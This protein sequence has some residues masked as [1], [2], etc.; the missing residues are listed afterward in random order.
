MKEKKI[1]EEEYRPGWAVER[2]IAWLSNFPR[3]TV[4]GSWSCM[5]RW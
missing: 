2:T 5:E 1:R 3:F 4:W